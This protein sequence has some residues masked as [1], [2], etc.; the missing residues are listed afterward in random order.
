MAKMESNLMSKRAIKLAVLTGLGLV[1]AGCGSA[2]DINPWAKKYPVPACPKI[3]LLKDT[4]TITVYRSGPGRDIT[5]IRYEADLKGFAGECEYIGEK[6]VYS[7]VKVTLKVGVEISRGPAEKS[8]LVGVSYFVAIPEFYPKPEGR[9]VFTAKVKFPENRNTMRILDEEV[10]LSI[11][12]NKTRKG[13]GT[14]VYI[15]F[16]LTPEQL[17]FNRQKRQNVR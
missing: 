12:L 15:G 3:Q 6:G 1:L 14:K 17:E 5:D 4:D 16:P 8:Q 7:A 2:Q 9:Q 11:P 10:E 13:P